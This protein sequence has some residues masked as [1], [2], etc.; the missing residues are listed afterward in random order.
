MEKTNHL[1]TTKTHLPVKNHTEHGPSPQQ[2]TLSEQS[3]FDYIFEFFMSD[4]A[5]EAYFRRVD[6]QLERAITKSCK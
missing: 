5:D 6:A 3:L 1:E 2:P 4:S